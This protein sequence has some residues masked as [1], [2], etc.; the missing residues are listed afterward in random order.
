M[1]QQGIVFARD[2]MAA[3]ILV[4]HTNETSAY[5]GVYQTQSCGS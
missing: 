3:A 2:V 4:P 5:D 1:L